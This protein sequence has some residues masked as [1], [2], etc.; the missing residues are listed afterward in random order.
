MIKVATGSGVETN[1]NVQCSQLK[2]VAAEFCCAIQIVT[3]FIYN[4]STIEMNDPPE[5]SHGNQIHTKS[6]YLKHWKQYLHHHDT[7]AFI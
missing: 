3:E 6:I 2:K 5:I 1:A 7:W 4:F